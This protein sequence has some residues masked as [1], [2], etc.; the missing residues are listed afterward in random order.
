MKKFVIVRREGKL[1]H[2]KGYDS[3]E[4][5]ANDRGYSYY[6]DVIETGIIDNGNIFFVECRDKKHIVKRQYQKELFDS[7][8]IRARATESYY[9]YNIYSIKEGD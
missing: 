7:S 6:N 5:I 1:K 9:K 2:L 8:L 4:N 3:H